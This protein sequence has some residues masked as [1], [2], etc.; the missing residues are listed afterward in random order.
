ML[1]LSHV[2]VFIAQYSTAASSI[3]YV[4]EHRGMAG[5]FLGVRSSIFN[6][7]LPFGKIRSVPLRRLGPK[8]GPRNVP[9]V[10]FVFVEVLFCVLSRHI[11]FGIVRL[12]V[13]G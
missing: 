1:C 6:V 3:R 5:L 9:G 7:I 13:Y 12:I 8:N 2:V 11:G 4:L 10:G